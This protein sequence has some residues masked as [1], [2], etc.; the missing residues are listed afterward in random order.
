MDVFDTTYAMPPDPAPSLWQRRKRW[1]LIGSGALLVLVLLVVSVLFLRVRTPASQDADTLP[2]QMAET[3]AVNCA[4]GSRDG[5]LRATAL[6]ANDWSLCDRITDAEASDVCRDAVRLSLAVATREWSLCNEMSNE[7]RRGECQALADASLTSE[8]CRALPNPP[9]ERCAALEAM[10]RAVEAED[11]DLCLS[12][13]LPE[14]RDLC[15]DV[16]YS[17]DRD[18]P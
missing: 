12:I 14:V 1:I 18:A 9:E 5:C 16:T 7:A 17:S 11:S 13:A 3:A 2:E 8:E 15:L 10:D 6:S 4:G